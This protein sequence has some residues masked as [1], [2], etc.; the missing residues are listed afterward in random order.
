MAS[1]NHT[2]QQAQK[3]T[4]DELPSFEELPLDRT[5]PPHSAWFVW[6]SADQLGCLNH[7]TPARV[8]EAAREIRTG[9][10]VGL[11]WGL[12]QMRV[13]PFYR[14]KLSHEIFSIG[15]DINVGNYVIK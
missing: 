13:P 3:P 2:D 10:S 11:N 15:T 12:D 1:S 9:V 6:G 4:V 7:L 5:H 14:S 8:T